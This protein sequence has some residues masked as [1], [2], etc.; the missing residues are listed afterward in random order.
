MYGIGSVSIYVEEGIGISLTEYAE[1][2]EY[3]FLET[4]WETLDRYN[5]QTAQGLPAEIF[6]VLASERVIYSF[7]YLSDDGAT[8]TIFYT[9]PIDPN[10]EIGATL[11][12]M[13]RYSFDT[14][15]VN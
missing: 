1:L 14:F 8:V 3:D 5:V 11:Y 4:D 6:E 9:F 10:D 7:T 13:A 2:L 12:S 15:V